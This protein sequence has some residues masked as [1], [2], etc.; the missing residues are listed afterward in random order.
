MATTYSEKGIGLHEAVARAGHWLEQ[1][2]GVWVSSDDA[3]VQVIIDGYSLDQAKAE[4]CALVLA[5]AAALRN[6][7][8]DQVAPGEMAAWPIKRAE[9]EAF[10]AVGESADCPALRAE[11]QERQITLAQLVA[12]VN[13]K[14]ARFMV[15]EAMIGGTDGRHRDAI[16]ALTTFAAVEAYDYTTGWPAV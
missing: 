7:V 4:R 9:A 12:K 10:D 16:K 11:A 2:D 1:R 13:A 15:T 14:A 8:T 5:H 3:T 6:M